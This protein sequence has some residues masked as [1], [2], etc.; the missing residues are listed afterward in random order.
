MKP[1]ISTAAVAAAAE[2]NLPSFASLY[3]I[4]QLC[5]WMPVGIFL[6]LLIVNPFVYLSA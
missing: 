3:S 1:T 2:S 4:K 6:A 5:V